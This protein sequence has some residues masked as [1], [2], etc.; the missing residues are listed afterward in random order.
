MRSKAIVLT[1]L[2]LTAAVARPE[3]NMAR[4]VK[5]ST[6][7][8]LQGNNKACHELLQIAEQDKDMS[9]RLR[10]VSLVWDQ[11]GLV[12]LV[13]DDP[14]EGIRKA[15]FERLREDSGAFSKSC[16]RIVKDPNIRDVEVQK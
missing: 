2:G 16:P 8:D 4:L 13:L 3:P 11:Q 10:A 15:A 9:I 5:L 1:V 12:D 14:D 7:C 6:Q